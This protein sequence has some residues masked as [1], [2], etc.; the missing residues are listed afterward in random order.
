MAQLNLL[1]WRELRRKELNR[2]VI[3]IA[4]GVA[5]LMCG[6]VYWAYLYMNNQ[7]EEQQQ[8][9]TYLEQEIQK[10]ERELKEVN[11]VKKKKAQLLSRMEVIQK[12]QSDR[13]RMVRLFDG[14]AKN[15]PKGMY[16]SLFQIKG[17]KITLK[18]SADSNGTVSKFMRLIESSEYFT[19]P[20]LNVI[21][22][23]NSQGLRVSNFT[24]IFNFVKSKK[25][26]EQDEVA[27][28]QTAKSKVKK[29]GGK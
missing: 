11:Q 22:I 7:I 5:L 26:S 10:V 18:G 19:T 27:V 29:R 20:N 15:L 28:Q 2:Q 17:N 13:T 23:K 1:P 9:N 24:L 21:N 14:L 25:E 6:L 12:L 4:V 3:N 8:R 16:L